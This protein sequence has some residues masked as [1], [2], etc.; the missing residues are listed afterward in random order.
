MQINN[1]VNKWIKSHSNILESCSCKTLH[2]PTHICIAG[3]VFISKF[4][5]GIRIVNREGTLD[6]IVIKSQSWESYLSLYCLEHTLNHLVWILDTDHI[7][8]RS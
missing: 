8:M 7:G 4:I 3:N 1:F 6:T 5:Y 2:P